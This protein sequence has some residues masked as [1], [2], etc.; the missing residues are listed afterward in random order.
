V[1]DVEFELPT[2]PDAALPSLPQERR[3]VRPN[4]QG[5]E[6]LSEDRELA[7]VQAAERLEGPGTLD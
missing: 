7:G 4:P 5:F 6:L 1:G 2:C 3:P